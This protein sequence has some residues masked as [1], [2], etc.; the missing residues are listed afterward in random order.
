MVISGSVRFIIC[1]QMIAICYSLSVTC[2]LWLA[3]CYLLS[4]SFHLRLDITCKNLFL[5]LV[6]VHLV[7]FS[8][9]WHPNNL[10]IFT[11][12]SEHH[13]VRSGLPCNQLPLHLLM[14]QHTYGA[15]LYETKF[16][17]WK[18]GKKNFLKA[19]HFSSNISYELKNIS[20][21]SENK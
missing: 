19:H 18:W 15:H 6:V 14:K 17:R 16:E 4:K 3:K 7:I 12:V 21:C 8:L 13:I 1:Y 10:K 20:I 5:S 9:I 11:F 2:Y